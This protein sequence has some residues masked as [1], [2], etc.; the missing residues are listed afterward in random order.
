M[1]LKMFAK[2]ESSEASRCP[3]LLLTASPNLCLA[4]KGHYD[5]L[6]SSWTDRSATSSRLGL[7]DASARDEFPLD[8]EEIPVFQELTDADF[9]LFWTFG[10]LLRVLDKSIP[11][12]KFWG[13]KR[14]AD[15]GAGYPKEV[16][17][18]RFRTHYFHKMPA[19]AQTKFAGGSVIFGEI[20]TIIKG[21]LE[22]LE[23]D[24][25]LTKEEYLRYIDA[26]SNQLSGAEM[27]L[28]YQ[29]FVRYQRLL[30][31]ENEWDLNDAVRCIYR[32]SKMYPDAYEALL[33]ETLAVD[34]VQ[35]LVS[36]Q[37][38]IR[39]AIADSYHRGKSLEYCVFGTLKVLLEWGKGKRNCAFRRRC[40][41]SHQLRREFPLCRSEGAVLL[42]LF[43]THG[44]DRAKDSSNSTKWIGGRWT[45]SEAQTPDNELP[46]CRTNRRAW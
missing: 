41:S 31:R 21:S 19:E 16:D 18:E 25:D 28:V 3:Q 22:S 11:G 29:C 37:S 6:R 12:K 43:A 26:R 17:G 27:A 39:T 14:T 30:Q 33:L 13:Y 40:R 38:Y 46:F 24:R 32:R 10:H 4:I 45:S 8:P 44:E 34:E 20:Q 7:V 36:R 42:Q 9:P 15:D 5:K 2:A 1:V 35:D 23:L